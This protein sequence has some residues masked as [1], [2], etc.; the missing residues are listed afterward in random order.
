MLFAAL[1]SFACTIFCLIALISIS[2]DND[3]VESVNWTIGES[4]LDPDVF[5]FYVGLSRLVIDSDITHIGN[6]T[7]PSYIEWGS[8]DCD[9][10]YCEDCEDAASSV[11]SSAIIAFVTCI[12]TLQTDLQRSTRKGDL[13][14][15]KFMAIFTGIIGTITNL[16]ALSAYAD[17]CFSNLPDSFMGVDMDYRLGPAFNC[18]LVATILKPIDVFIHIF[19]PVVPHVDIDPNSAGSTN[20]KEALVNNK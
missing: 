2:H 4:S 14:C 5:T 18:M 10:G 20:F 12:P 8:D 3:V 16:I 6:T 7:I 15:Q 9:A 1:L 13:N 11:I 17:M 19:T